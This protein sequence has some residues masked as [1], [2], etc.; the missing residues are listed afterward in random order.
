MFMHLFQSLVLVQVFPT[1]FQCSTLQLTIFQVHGYWQVSYESRALEG[2]LWGVGLKIRH[3]WCASVVSFFLVLVPFG[4][5]I[6][7][8]S[9]HYLSM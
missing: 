8:F 1:E 7:L 9:F 2:E 5:D 3:E 6:P 4:D